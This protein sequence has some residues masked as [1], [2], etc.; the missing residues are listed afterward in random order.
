MPA[1][2]LFSLPAEMVA[3]IRSH[4]PAAS[5]ANMR[6]ACRELHAITR[7][8]PPLSKRAWRRFHRDFEDGARRTKVPIHLACTRCMKLLK[9]S[10]FQDSQ[11]KR[12]CD[13]LDG[14]VCFQCGVMEGYYN[15]R[16]F[17]HQKEVC[18][19]C[20][21]CPEPK[22]REEEAVYAFREPGLPIRDGVGQADKG[23]K[24]WCKEC[25]RV[26]TMYVNA[27]LV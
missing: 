15:V 19:S 13:R 22:K 3:E 26:V 23:G 9:P 25:W 12:K 10:R 11:A 8:A 16:D 17:L 14:R 7:P 24:R 20:F 2:T 21:G 18:F 1:A 27:R 5:I 4:L 6:L